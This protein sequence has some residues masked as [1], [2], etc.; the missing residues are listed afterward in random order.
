MT[1]G[2]STMD[3]KPTTDDAERPEAIPTPDDTQDVEGHNLLPDPG[4]GREMAR[5]REMEIERRLKAHEVQVEAKHP[6]EPHPKK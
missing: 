3:G 5:A 1:D 6:A 4:L 2:R